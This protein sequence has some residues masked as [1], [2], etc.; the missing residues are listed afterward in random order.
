M[1]IFRDRSRKMLG[2]SQSTY[3][4]TSLRQFNVDNFKKGYLSIGHKI[5]LSKRDCLTTL[6]ERE[7]MSRIPYASVVGS[8]IYTVTCMRSDVA[9]SLGVMSRYQ[10]VSDEKHWKIAKV[11]L[12]YLRNTK[13]Q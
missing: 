12:K 6:K 9:C 3:I 1:K 5:T 4:D 2:P 8:I 11:I 13:D 7:R 10:Y